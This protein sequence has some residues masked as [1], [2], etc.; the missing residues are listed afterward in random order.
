LLV[1]IAVSFRP[2]K[3]TAMET[4]CA[5]RRSRRRDELMRER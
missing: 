3:E 5:P 1:S 4:T 2:P